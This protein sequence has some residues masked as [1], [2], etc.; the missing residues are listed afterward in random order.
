MRVKGEIASGRVWV[1]GKEILPDE[2]LKFRNHSPTGFSWGYGGS[3]PAQLALALTMVA[4]E[5]LKAPVMEMTP[6]YQDV[7][8][9]FIATLPGSDFEQE[10]PNRGISIG[11]LRAMTTPANNKNSSVTVKIDGLKVILIVDGRESVRNFS[12]AQEAGVCYDHYKAL[13]IEAE[14]AS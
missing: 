3:G 11:G 4:A 10:L 7:K 8:W 12:T 6:Y 9:K 5:S 1:N 14:K 2:S 13:I